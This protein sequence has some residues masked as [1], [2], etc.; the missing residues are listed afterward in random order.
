VHLATQLLKYLS[1]AVNNIVK[2]YIVRNAY[3]AHPENVLLAMLTDE[4]SNKRAKA[5]NIV[6]NLETRS[7]KS[8]H[9]S[10]NSMFRK[11]TLMRAIGTNLLI[12]TLL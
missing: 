11:L 2:P 6:L 7:H 1:P 9:K 10:E 12:G 3:F 4:D 5:V 8:S